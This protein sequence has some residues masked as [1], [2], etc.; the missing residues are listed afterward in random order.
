MNKN[1]L[2]LLFKFDINEFQQGSIVALTYTKFH[3]SI[4]IFADAIVIT[5]KKRQ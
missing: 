5:Y 1:C 4:L 3:R 2:K